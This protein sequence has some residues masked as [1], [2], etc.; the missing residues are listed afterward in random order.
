MILNFMLKN[1][2]IKL[3]HRFK[4]ISG[5]KCVL[6]ENKIYIYQGTY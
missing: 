1:N 5:N 3:G 4:I 6:L 2:H